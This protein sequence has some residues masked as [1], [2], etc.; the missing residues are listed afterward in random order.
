MSGMER[1]LSWSRG[2]S[3]TVLVVRIVIVLGVIVLVVQ[4]ITGVVRELGDDLPL[5]SHT[6]T[7]TS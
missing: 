6:R 5:S 7:N 3:S 4:A 2:L 1:R